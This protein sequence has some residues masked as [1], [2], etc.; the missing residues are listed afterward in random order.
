[1]ADRAL[2]NRVDLE[3][4][5]HVP[6]RT[7]STSQSL[8]GTKGQAPETARPTRILLLQLLSLR[9]HH[10]IECKLGSAALVHLVLGFLRLLT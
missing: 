2:S 7:R 8:P 4:G 5:E 3:S 9:P 6:S 10:P 1:M